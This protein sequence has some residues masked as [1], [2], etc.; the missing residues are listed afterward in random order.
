MT[1]SRVP[2]RH[3]RTHRNDLLATGE[4]ALNEPLWAFSSWFLRIECEL[5]G[6]VRMVNEADVPDR[7]REMPIR[8]LL[9]WIRHH[10]CDG[11]ETRAELLTGIE[12]VSSRPVRRIVLIAVTAH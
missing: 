2:P 1:L 5:C 7:L 11:R 6:E 4:E 9:A 3:W 8:D 12:G 10:C